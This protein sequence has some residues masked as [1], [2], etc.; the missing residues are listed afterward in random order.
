M[1]VNEQNLN[2]LSEYLKQTL[3]PNTRRQAEQYLY[4]VE[5]NPNFSLLLLTLV[6]NPS[7]DPSVR[8]A[9]ALLFKNFVKRNWE[10]EGDNTTIN[11][12][13]RTAIKT[14][15]VGLM[16]GVP[17]KLQIQLSEALSIIADSDFP[18]KWSNLIPELVSKLSPTDFSINNGVLQTAHSIFKRWRSQFRTNE[19]FTEIKFVLDQFCEPYLQLFKATDAMV[20]SNANNGEALKV[21]SQTILLLVKIFYSLNCQDLPVFFED[22]M[23]EFMGLL[24]KYLNYNNP[25]LVS[26][27][28]D[29][30]GPLEK[31]KASICESVELYAHRYEEDFP[32][33]PKF[34]ETVWSLLTVTS[35][36]PKNDLLVSKAIS[37]ITTIA[38]LQRHRDLF[39]VGDT[40]K[41]MCEKI[42]L[43]NM[44]L[45]TSDEELFEDDPIEYIRR[46]LEGSDNDTRRRAA[47]DLVR[48]LLEQFESAITSTM[49]NY[50]SHYLQNYN[51]NPTANW[52]DKDTAVYLL[53]SIA[54]KHSS[55]QH[56]VTKTNDFINVVEFF[57]NNV[58][59]DLQAPFGSVHPI[60]KVDALKYLYTFRNQMN[61]SDLV[62]C[63]PLLVTHLSSDNYVVYTYASICLERILFMKKER[64]ILFNA[65]D[66]QPHVE[67]ILTNLFKLI[68]QGVTPE[69]LAENDH[70]MK[71]VMRVILISREEI[72]PYVSV[73]LNK[74]TNIV[75]I[76]SR[77]PSNPR[78]NHYAFES[79]GALIRFTCSANPAAI[80]DFEALLFTPFQSILQ[81]DVTEFTPYVFQ[82]LSQMLDTHQESELPVAYQSMLTPLLQPTLWEQQG[83]IPALSR[84]I[85][86]YLNNGAKFIVVQNQLTPILGIFQKLIASKLNDTHGF[87]ILNALVRNVPIATLNSYLKAVITLLLTR[88]QSSRTPKFTKGFVYFICSYIVVVDPQGSSNSIFELFDSIQPGLFFEIVKSF[89]VP[90]TQAIHGMVERKVAA[91]AMTR[92]LTQSTTMLNEPYFTQWTIVLDVIIQILQSPQEVAGD[93]NEDLYAI[94][95]EETGYQA[96]FS[97]LATSKQATHDP[98]SHIQDPKTYLSQNLAKVC[99]ANPNRISSAIQQGLPKDSMNVLSSYLQSAGVGSLM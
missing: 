70:L 36:E 2:A 18:E 5:K 34:V 44:S 50:I 97:K 12:T 23:P 68:E 20:E 56:G 54:S 22:H 88:L 35:L 40:L 75:S 60:L 55:T 13:D 72:I 87:E 61:K 14:R 30:A 19:L 21:L 43:P 93:E 7:A 25:L 66:I 58:L 1:E 4:S 80:G 15:I 73:V 17:A 59:K 48:G 71:A 24:H 39:L 31:I 53:I 79:I 47:S 27:D 3:D 65:K 28:E 92:M 84:L 69:K 38:K 29:E 94:D 6:E 76:I 96:S 46:D 8:F 81:Q 98:A 89:L 67:G 91:V 90:E 52:K 42:I 16:I 10:Q 11:E 86:S 57:A 45:R 74:L 32:M 41:N 77:N 99:Q 51:S 95:L 49:S 9:A 83:N 85:Q 33:L 63:F 64:T 78:F 62:N 82:L 26:D 37:V